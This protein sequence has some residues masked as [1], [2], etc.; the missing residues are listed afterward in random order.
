MLQPLLMSVDLKTMPPQSKEILQN[1]E[2]IAV[3]Q[4]PLGHQGRVMMEE[5]YQSKLGTGKIHVFVKPL[6][7]K[8]F[9]VVIYNSGSFAGPQNVTVSFQKVK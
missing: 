1:M 4:D 2:V 5:S 7:D 9:A 3:N 8:N 6:A